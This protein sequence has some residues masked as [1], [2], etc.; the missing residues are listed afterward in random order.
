MSK[1]KLVPQNRS[2][3]FR[4][5]FGYL[6]GDFGCNMS[7]SLISGYMMLF[8]PQ[9]IGISL[10]H[11][12]FIIL[13]TKIWDAINDPLI[14]ALAD[15]L[16]PKQGDKFRPW[17]FWG[18]FPLAFSA[19]IM[20]LNT[21]A[22]PYWSRILVC[23]VGYMIWDIS[24]TVV[25]VPYGSMNSTISSD[26][27]E[28]SQLSTWRSFGAIIAALPISIIVPQIAYKKAV[29]DGVEKSI[30]QGQNL[31]LLS[32]IM[33]VVALISFQL[34]YRLS[35]ERIKHE[36]K[37]EQKFSYIQA[38]KSFF[39]NRAMLAVAIAALAQV[40]F[41]MSTQTTGALVY[42]MYFGD[43]SLSSFSVIAM[44]LP[45]LVTA[46]LVKPMVKKYGKKA[47][48]SWPMLLSVAAYGVVLVIPQISVP[49]Y[50]IMN[51]IASLGSGFYTMVGWA[52]ISDCMDS[53]ELQTGRREEGSIYATYSMV[54]KMGQGLGQSL[55][56]FIF[57]LI[58]PGLDMNNPSTWNVSYGL[59]IKNI[60]I[61]LPMIGALITFICFKV[62]YDLDQKKLSEI[63]KALGRN[64]EV[65]VPVS[66]VEDLAANSRRGA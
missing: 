60:S 4:D 30:L 39:S 2:F 17:I 10:V 34:L 3:G 18:S 37:P 45:M 16:T 57:A 56:P 26:P 11:Y 47:L 51:V 49:V 14:G 38:I 42:Q 6:M 58:I 24:Y 12:G 44:L 50:I 59:T 21:Q 15:R 28:R 64:G 29:V 53:I 5:K 23:V 35:T 27:V 43:G 48:C 33:G 66:V 46:P 19:C 8:F 22:W 52:L 65:K 63:H 55:I 9:H 1:G 40:V 61:L 32:L 7:F 13:F 36:A 25:N 20:F 31:F 41:M 62:M 54:R